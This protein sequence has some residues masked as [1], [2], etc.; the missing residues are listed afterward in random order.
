VYYQINEVTKQKGCTSVQLQFGSKIKE[1][2]WV[3]TEV[4]AVEVV[5][6]MD[7]QQRSTK[8]LVQNAKKNAKSLSSRAAIVRFT[9]RIVFLNAK[10]AA[11]N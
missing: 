7:V 4:V 1:E 5:T 2:V 8:Q 3:L 6:E 11:A 10:I 9:A